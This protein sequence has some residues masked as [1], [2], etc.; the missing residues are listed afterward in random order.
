MRGY[1]VHPKGKAICGRCGNPVE[2]V[3]HLRHKNLCRSCYNK[4]CNEKVKYPGRK[5]IEIPGDHKD[6]NHIIKYLLERG[7]IYPEECQVCGKSTAL[8]HHPDYRHL[9]LIEWLCEKHHQGRHF[10]EKYDI[11]PVDYTKDVD[12]VEFLANR[13]CFK[14]LRDVY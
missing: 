14:A 6:A 4:Q 10:G 12:V 2:D 13:K 3:L 9:L 7:I 1:G 8:A 11:I 5:R